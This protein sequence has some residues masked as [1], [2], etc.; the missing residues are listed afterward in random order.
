M[1]YKALKI[2]IKLLGL[3]DLYIMS[4]LNIIKNNMN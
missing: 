4:I 1:Y 2:E 3:K